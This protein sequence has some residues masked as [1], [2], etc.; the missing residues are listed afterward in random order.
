MPDPNAP[1]CD[2]GWLESAADDPCV[3]VVFNREL[4]EYHL[5][6]SGEFGGEMMIYHCPFC[7]G[8]APQSRRNKLFAEI[9]I[10]EMD[11]LRILTKDLKTLPDVLSTLG[12]PDQ[13]IANGYG[14]MTPEKDGQSNRTEHLRM[15][16][17]ASISPTA[18]VEVVVYPTDRVHFMFTGKYVGKHEG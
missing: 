14:H 17:Y 10:E 12:T 1:E 16:R 8:R 13:D 9:S 2:C 15:L 11:R 4:N 6:R 5:I 18:D 3:S 7:G